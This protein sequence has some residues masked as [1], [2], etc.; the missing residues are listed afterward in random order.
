MVRGAEGVAIDGKAQRGR[1]AFAGT[2]GCPVHALSACTHTVGA[3]LAQEDITGHVEKA[4][5]ELSVAPRLIARLGWRGRVF[6]GD[7]LFCQR[8]CPRILV[9]TVRGGW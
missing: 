8:G 3:V 9:M 4:A 6:T 7:A 2:A 1:L 5:A